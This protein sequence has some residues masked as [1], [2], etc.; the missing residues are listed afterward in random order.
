[1]TKLNLSLLASGSTLITGTAA[2]WQQNIGRELLG[3]H[4]EAD[5]TGVEIVSRASA[6]MEAGR[7]MELWA[8]AR[9]LNGGRFRY[10][11]VVAH[12]LRDVREL[13]SAIEAQLAAS[14]WQRP[15]LVYRDLATSVLPTLPGSTWPRLALELVEEL[16]VSVLTVA[17]G[18]GHK[19]VLAKPTEYAADRVWTC[20]AMS[21]ER[22]GAKLILS[23]PLGIEETY[24][25]TGT[26]HTGVMTFDL[27][28]ELID[29]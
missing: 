10:R 11:I 6:A 24:E 7:D 15:V 5:G 12:P 21:G 13:R 23:K 28:E 19:A 17:H 3:R 16:G 29:A 18:G 20:E 14:D 2:S 9:A 22:V 4:L 27:K 26:S 8:G 25:F 1:M